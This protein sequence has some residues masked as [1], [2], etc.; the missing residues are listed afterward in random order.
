MPEHTPYRFQPIHLHWLS[1][2]VVAG[3]VVSHIAAS[4]LPTGRTPLNVWVTIILGLVVLGVYSLDHL[5]DNRRT[6]KPKT[7]RHQFN[8]EYEPLVWRLV[9]GTFV[10]ATALSWLIPSDLWK[11]GGG[12]VAFVALYLWGVSKLPIKSHRQ[13]MKE[14]ITS[15][16]YACG[17]WA[18]TWFLGYEV[19][20]ESIV[21]GI[22]F[23]LI[24]VQS[25]LLFSHFEAIKYRESYNLARWL[26]RA[27]TMKVL[28]GITI[29]AAITCVTVC[30]MTDYRYVQRLA[31]ILLSMSLVHLWMWRNPEKIIANERFRIWGELVFVMPWLVL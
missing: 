15:L 6:E 18:S 27:N 22:L 8:R 26:K 3:A 5:L 14:P 31:I 1:L 30:L 19:T 9:I 4:R 29:V 28:K 21:L 13:A 12:M 23:Y 16:I 20:W 11:F 2:D 7:Q 17:V 25:L 10:V 24:T